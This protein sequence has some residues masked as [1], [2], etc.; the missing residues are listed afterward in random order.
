[1]SQQ[2]GLFCRHVLCPTVLWPGSL[3]VS[4]CGHQELARCPTLLGVR[5][6]LTQGCH[7][8]SD[9]CIRLVTWFIPSFRACNA[10][11][12]SVCTTWP[13]PVLTTAC[14]AVWSRFCIVF[15]VLWL[16]NI[17][18][19]RRYIGYGTLRCFS[20]RPGDRHACRRAGGF[21]ALNHLLAPLCLGPRSNGH[22][23][24][25]GNL[26]LFRLVPARSGTWPVRSGTVLGLH[27][28]RTVRIASIPVRSCDSRTPPTG[29]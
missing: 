15:R 23:S 13:H 11:L 27:R 10:C 20:A 17:S 5:S 9:D 12:H 26:G 8:L 29:A 21:L 18:S 7:Q 19:K 22:I 16:A 4:I 1:M 14:S 6:S 2:G 28:P 24:G 3:P 25:P